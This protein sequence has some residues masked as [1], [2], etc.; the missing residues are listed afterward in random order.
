MVK[1]E[2][3]LREDR[4]EIPGALEFTQYPDQDFTL[5]VAGTRV[6]LE[7]WVAT[8]M[9]Y[10]ESGTTRFELYDLR[11]V[12]EAFGADE[13]RRLVVLARKQKDLRP[14]GSKTALCVGRAAHYGLSRIYSA[15]TEME[16]PWTT[17]GFTSIDEAWT[18]LGVDPSLIDAP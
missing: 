8:V 9:A 3:G 13:V 16:V 12:Q 18:W 14:P 17:R 11:D 15:M 5:F 2:F 4:M 6:T 7:G 1:W 10:V